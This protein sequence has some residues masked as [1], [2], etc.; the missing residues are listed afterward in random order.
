MSSGLLP[1]RG[2]CA[3]RGGA[4]TH[5]E[6]T[7]SAFRNAASL[8]AHQIEFD[9]RRTI[10]GE[11]V[12]I[13]DA[14][15][16]R[17]TGDRGKVSRWK[18][19]RLRELD[20]GRWKSDRFVGERIA[21]LAETLDAMPRDVWINLQIKKGE[22][23]AADVAE[24]VGERGRLDQVIVACGNTSAET[25]RAI[26]PKILIC[27]LAR[28]ETRLAYVDHAIAVGSDFVQFHHLRGPPEPELVER[29][30]RAGL[31]VNYFCDPQGCE[32]VPLFEAGIDFALVDDVASALWEVRAIGIEPITRD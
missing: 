4:A 12:V 27:N 28:Q 14:S 30:K 20:F 22:Q 18:L 16:D 7:L 9:V 25:A 32:L 11:I 31:R 26:A 29:A 3:H 6:N 23:V 24:L 1:A 19:A 8:G 15:V 17:T 13:H 10:D 21:T 5:P 2:I